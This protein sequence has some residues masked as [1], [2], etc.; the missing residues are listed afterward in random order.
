MV[1]TKWLLAERIC[2]LWA[3]RGQFYLFL[4]LKPKLVHL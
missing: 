1:T 4:D 2:G 3:A